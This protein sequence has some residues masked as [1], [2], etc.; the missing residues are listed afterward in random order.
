MKRK[1]SWILVLALVGLA[2]VAWAAQH[3]GDSAKMPEPKAEALWSYLEKQ[4][5]ESWPLWPGKE[6]LYE[7]TRPH[8]ALLTT[9]VNQPALEAI[10]NEAGEMPPGA[11]VVKENYKPDETLAAVTVMYKSKGF[12]SEH[13]DW[14]WLKREADG[15]VVASGKV[16]SCIAC[17][18]RK[19]DNDY[20]FTGQL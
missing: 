2:G 8:G 20:L 7:G 6:K 9:Y 5:Y 16:Q 13:N 3:K 17:H 14:F 19:A 10:E 4:E 18:S 15:T 11:I 12:D 1:L